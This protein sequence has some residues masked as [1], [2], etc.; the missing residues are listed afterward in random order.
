MPACGIMKRYAVALPVGV[1]LLACPALAAA[2]KFFAY[3][4]TTRTDFKS[5]FLA[6]AGTQNWG[7]D[8]AANDKDHSLDTNERLTLTGITH[9]LYDVKL[10]DKKGR[11]CIVRGV[12][13]TRE[14][15]FEIREKDL[16]GCR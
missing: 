11:T 12:D 16:S 8:Q 13:L 4:M 10:V 3:D 6:P 2:E 1:A 7:P 14:R 5:V 9:G 15:S